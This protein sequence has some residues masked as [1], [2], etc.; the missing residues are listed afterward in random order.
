MSSY[1]FV[2]NNDHDLH[3]NDDDPIIK[4]IKSLPYKNKNDMV[5]KNLLHIFIP[6]LIEGSLKQTAQ[7]ICDELHN[8]I[9]DNDC[10]IVFEIG[11]DYAGQCYD[12]FHHYSNHS[13]ADPLPTRTNVFLISFDIDD[14]SSN[15]NTFIKK[16]KS[17]SDEYYMIT[18]NTWAIYSL[19]LQAEKINDELIRFIQS[20]ANY[21]IARLTI[22]ELGHDFAE[23]PNS[24]RKQWFDNKITEH[25]NC[26]KIQKELTYP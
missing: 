17:L 12:L 25:N 7:I 2:F 19:N 10:L 5:T 1:L 13:N 4:K 20:L 6:K 14:N 9:P 23:Y 16:I 18:K 15:Y 21:D 8:F 26:K 3:Y 22:S 11:P 24:K